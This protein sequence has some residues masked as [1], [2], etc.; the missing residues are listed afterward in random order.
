MKEHCF[1]DYL[2]RTASDIDAALERYKKE[3]LSDVTSVNRTLEPLMA[4]FFK[5]CEGG[6]R[7]R[8]TLVKLGYEMLKHPTEEILKPA[9]AYEIFQTAVLIHDD[10]I[11]QSPIRRN[12][13]S[14]FTVLGGKQYGISQALCLGDIALFLSTKLIA[15]SHFEAYAKN[16]ALCSFT[17]VQFRTGLGELLDIEFPHQKHASMTLK[18][19]LTL[20]EY[21]TSYY[22]IA[23]PLQIGV[24]LAGGEAE[25]L[26]KLHAFGKFLGIAFQIQDDILGIFGDERTIGKSIMSD[27][28]EGK[29][30]ILWY[31]VFQNA[32]NNQKTFLRNTYGKKGAT[33]SE[34]QEMRKVCIA[35]NALSKS[36]EM[37]SKY[38]ESA[39]QEIPQ[40]PISP[41]HKNMLQD[42]CAYMMQRKK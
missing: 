17:G 16:Q 3:L 13:P 25:L 23:N 19:I 10:I 41:I 15:E 14:L 38:V 30:T 36:E 32:T 42:L 9:L 37:M 34:L 40:L 24:I 18:D 28:E 6:K 2:T 1:N 35:T 27:M 31:Y 29:I 26:K 39:Q 5:S 4:I 8:G 11:D 22:T 33:P 7:L 21:K 20:Y 12:Q